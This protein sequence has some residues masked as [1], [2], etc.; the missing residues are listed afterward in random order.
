MLLA[1]PAGR[2]ADRFGRLNMFL[3]GHVLLIVIYLVLLLPSSGALQVGAVLLLLG[4]YYAATDGVLMALA[5]TLLPASMQAT[6]MAVIVTGTSA[7]RLLSAVAFG[8]LW[9]WSGADAAL[10][11]FAAAL[12]VGVVVAALLP[13]GERRDHAAA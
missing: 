6:G 8:A 3:A 13:I 1:V 10:V 7:G 12:T 2:I 5:S 4:G 11:V 9:T